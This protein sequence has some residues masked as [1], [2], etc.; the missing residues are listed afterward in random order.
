MVH[1]NVYL[2]R[3]FAVALYE[4]EKRIKYIL[5]QQNYTFTKSKFS[6]KNISLMDWILMNIKGK[7]G[8]KNYLFVKVIIIFII[9]VLK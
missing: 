7:I 3:F 8:W 1:S 4:S 6:L 5:K 9:L 2:S